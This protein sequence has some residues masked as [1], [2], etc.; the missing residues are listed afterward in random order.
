MAE[1]FVQAEIFNNKNGKVMIEHQLFG[2]QV[3]RCES[4][5]IINDEERFG[6]R[7]QECD[8]YVRK[9][10]IVLY[11]LYEN[12]MVVADKIVTLTVIVNKM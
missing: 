1:N 4:V 9:S 3:F 5:K 10:D 8:V 11:K 12:M 6:V 7:I 2:R